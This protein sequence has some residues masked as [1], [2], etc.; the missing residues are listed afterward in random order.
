MDC[1]FDFF[2]MYSSSASPS[3]ILQTQD[4]IA[5]SAFGPLF[6]IWAYDLIFCCSPY[7]NDHQTPHSN[8]K[9]V[10]KSSI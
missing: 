5:I 8:T 10:R 1:F 6:S 9:R 3:N 7:S 2:S 4:G